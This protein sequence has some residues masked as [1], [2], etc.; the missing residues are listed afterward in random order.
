MLII[1]IVL[2]VV[3][4]YYGFQGSAFNFLIGALLLVTVMLDITRRRP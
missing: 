4:L 3:N 1:N 2:C